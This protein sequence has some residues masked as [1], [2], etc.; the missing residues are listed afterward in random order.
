MVSHDLTITV[1]RE[2][3]QAQGGLT[4]YARLLLL[5]LYAFGD[6]VPMGHVARHIGIAPG[7]LTSIVDRLESDGLVERSPGADR[8]S[9]NIALT[10]A[11]VTLVSDAEQRAIDEVAA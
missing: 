2:L 11:G 8:R 4:P 7:A 5:G 9:T 1:M 3:S 10:G 6:S